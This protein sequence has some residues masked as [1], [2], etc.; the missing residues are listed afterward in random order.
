MQAI[1]ELE[2]RLGRVPTDE[3]VAAAMKISLSDYRELLDDG[4]DRVT[5]MCTVANLFGGTY[6]SG[7][8]SVP[9]GLAT[10]N[11]L[12]N[13]GRMPRTR[14]TGRRSPWTARTSWPTWRFRPGRG[15]AA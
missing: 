8:G 5:A 2:Q 9:L 3:Q 13:D 11:T 6:K 4:S 14:S 12:M 1:G 10:L 7:A 15:W